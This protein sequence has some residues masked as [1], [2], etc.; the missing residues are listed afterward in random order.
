MLL[1]KWILARNGIEGERIILRTIASSPICSSAPPRA[2]TS[3]FRSWGSFEADRD[4]EPNRRLL[5]IQLNPSLRL[6]SSFTALLRKL[7]TG[8]STSRNQ[9]AS[10]IRSLAGIARGHIDA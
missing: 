10:G 2:G 1:A 6:T 8:R 7:E 4:R 9:S 5:H 3:G